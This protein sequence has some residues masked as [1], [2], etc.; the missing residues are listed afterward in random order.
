MFSGNSTTDI[1]VASVVT[2]IL[3]S[4]FVNPLIRLVSLTFYAASIHENTVIVFIRLV[5]GANTQRRFARI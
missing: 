3:M 1:I 5:L 2:Q 4:F